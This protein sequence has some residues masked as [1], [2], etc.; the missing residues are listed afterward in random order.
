VAAVGINLNAFRIGAEPGCSWSPFGPLLLAGI[1]KSLSHFQQFLDRVEKNWKKG[2]MLS[3]S[4]QPDIG[5][6]II[7]PPK[8]SPEPCLKIRREN[9]SHH[10]EKKLK[11]VH[12]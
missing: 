3:L 7:A 6:R 9:S 12:V 2:G 11:L 8:K 1:T 4:P 10:D 5:V